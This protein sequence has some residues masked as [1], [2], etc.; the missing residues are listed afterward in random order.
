MLKPDCVNK[1]KR[2]IFNNYVL[3]SLERK[4]RQTFNVRT[5]IKSHL[6]LNSWLPGSFNVWLPSQEPNKILSGSTNSRKLQKITI[7]QL[8]HI[9]LHMFQLIAHLNFLSAPRL[10]PMLLVYWTHSFICGAIVHNYIRNKTSDF[11]LLANTLYKTSIVE[12]SVIV[13]ICMLVG[14]NAVIPNLVLFCFVLLSANYEPIAATIE[15]YRLLSENACHIL[16]ILIQVYQIWNYALIMGPTYLLCMMGYFSAYLSLWLLCREL[17]RRVKLSSV[18]VTTSIEE[19][20]Q[21]QIYTAL[22]NQCFQKHI[23]IPYKMMLMLLA[24]LAGGSVLRPEFRLEA[25][26]ASFGASIYAVSCIY[27]ALVAGYYVPGKANY[28]SHLIKGI[29]KRR[30]D[31]PDIILKVQRKEQKLV[32]GQIRSKMQIKIFFGATN[33]YERGTSLNMLDVLVDKT[34]AFLLLR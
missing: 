30:L 16:K 19:Y 31:E 3:S 24:V 1:M 9:I 6:N 32:R 28:S 11:A 20:T 10:S 29:W 15:T 5:I 33:F 2:H 26:P 21:L 22:V 12:D 8:V 25:T 4:L 7:I 18:S 13:K 14:F 23:A 27:F 17:K 34:V